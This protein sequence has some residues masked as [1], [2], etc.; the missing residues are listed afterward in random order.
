MLRS[1][2]IENM[3]V[4]RSAD[5]EFSK[6]LNCLTG[7]TGS[8]KT[9]IVGSL[10]LLLGSRMSKDVIRTGENRA[11]VSALFTDLAPDVRDALEDMGISCEEDAVLLQ[12]TVESSGRTTARINGSAV[13]QAMHREIATRL[14]SIHGQRDNQKLLQPASQMTEL[15]R[16]AGDEP[17]L[18]AYAEAYRTLCGLRTQYEDLQKDSAESERLREMLAYQIKDIEKYKPVPG[19]EDKLQEKLKTLQNAERIRK[20]LMFAHYLLYGSDKAAASLALDKA[21]ESL[22][23]LGDLVPEA[24]ELADKLAVLQSETVDVAERISELL[25]PEEDVTGLIDRMEGRLDALDKLKRKYGPD[26]GDVL[27]YLE[28][29]KTRLSNIENVADRLEDLNEQ[30]RTQTETCRKAGDKLSA[31]RKA[32]AKKASEEIRRQLTYLDM[33]N[34]QFEIRVGDTGQFTPRGTDTVEFY[35]APNPGEAMTPLADTASGGELAR[36][37]LALRCV[38]N[39]KNG[40][41]VSVYDEV[42]TGISG[43]T[44]RKVG[45]KLKD[46]SESGQ[47]IC[48]THSAQIASLADTHFRVGKIQEGERVR[49]EV[50]LLEGEERVGEIA[51][52]L[53]GI[54][55]T[56]AQRAAAVDMIEEGKRKDS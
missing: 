1:L 24:K 28:N 34:V 17:A 19:E 53:G 6:G 3:A 33:P 56:A 38:L 12:R 37:M 7:E 52:I 46:I 40:V 14:L 49:T 45:F 29:A 47:V 36:V 2:H 35:I 26:I 9:L 18:A 39:E 44:A 15:D 42:D 11:L 22:R 32:A 21:G 13:T 54:S 50:T 31:L 30:I 8:G 25:P 5:L 20:Q 27:S 48:V 51:R 10:N 23:K 41:D 4:I 43:K 55:V 16:Y